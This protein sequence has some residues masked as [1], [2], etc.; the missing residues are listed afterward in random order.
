MKKRITLG[1]LACGLVLALAG[2]GGGDGGRVGDPV[3]FSEIENTTFSTITQ[4]E[5]AQAGTQ[6]AWFALWA[7]H[8]A[9]FSPPPALPPV[10]FG[11]SMVA[12]V[13]LGND[14]LCTR[15]QVQSVAFESLATPTLAAVIRVNYRVIPPNPA[16]LCAAG[17]GQPSQIIR[18]EHPG[19]AQLKFVKVD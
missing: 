16:A 15:V 10:D 8:K 9:N 5:T 12:A 2:C 3:A 18:I 7:R 6:Q 14:S 11:T 1:L 19:T 17:I 13:F 4:F